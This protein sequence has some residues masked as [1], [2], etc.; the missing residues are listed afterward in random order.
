M[1]KIA[2]SKITDIASQHQLVDS[3]DFS[4]ILFSSVQLSQVQFF[5]V[6]DCL[7]AHMS[8]CLNA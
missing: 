7:N 4:T 3:F 6:G 2:F 8:K 1:L 5:S